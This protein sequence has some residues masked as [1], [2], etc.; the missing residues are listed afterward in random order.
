MAYQN[1]NMSVI[2][3]ANGWTMWQYKT[4]D[5]IELIDE[6]LHYLPKAVV[7]LMAVGDVIYITSK[8]ITYQRQIVD[9]HNGTATIGR[10]S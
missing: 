1:K 10:V 4:E 3:Y 5:S 2:A 6:D 7:N 9:I 8:G